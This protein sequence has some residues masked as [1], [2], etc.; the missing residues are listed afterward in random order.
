ML[1]CKK[2]HPNFVLFLLDSRDIC[3]YVC[4]E[5]PRECTKA[6]Y[7]AGALERA[8]IEKWLQ[9]EAQSFDAPS[10]ELAFHLA[11]APWL[12]GAAPA[13]PDDEARVAE[14]ER[15]LLRVLGVY[16]DALARTRFL[17]GDEFTI[18]DLSHLPNSHYIAGSERGRMLLGAKKHVAR[19][20]EDISARAAWRQVV[21][22]QGAHPAGSFVPGRP[23]E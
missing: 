21:A 18:A 8:S 12:A 1:I 11:F 20:Y 15:R 22:V 2:R 5:F 4:T 10:S 17:A 13:A 7:G 9:A 3:R 16:D 6:L 14:S 19:W 23:Y